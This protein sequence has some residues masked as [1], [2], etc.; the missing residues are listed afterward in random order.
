MYLICLTLLNT[1]PL[2]LKAHQ[3]NMRIFYI[4]N[5]GILMENLK[6]EVRHWE[7]NPG[8]QY[9]DKVWIIKCMKKKIYRIKYNYVR[10]MIWT[11][12]GFWN[13]AYY[14]I[15][16]IGTIPLYNLINYTNHAR[17]L[18]LESIRSLIVN[19]SAT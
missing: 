8:W 9:H 3:D 7:S 4:K 14:I 19:N 5:S 12:T 17:I 13:T 15:K 18:N 1:F 10:I 11:D 6:L 2:C 16:A